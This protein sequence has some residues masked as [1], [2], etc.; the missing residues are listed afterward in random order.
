MKAVAEWEVV[1]ST[2]EQIEA[3]AKECRRMVSRRALL[4]AGVAV[5]PIPGV[6]WAT[7]VGVLLKVLPDINRKFGLSAEQVERLAPDRRL[8]VFKAITAG[9]TMLVGRIVT[10]E[11]VMSMLRMVGVRLSA[12]QAVK[13][14][15]I[16]GQGLSAVLTYGA[17]RYVCE[18]HIKQCVAICEQLRLPAPTEVVGG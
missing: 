14:V 18:Q 10:R 3:V 1:P 17:L 12:Q 11:L 15:P 7:N 6:D 5:V 13:Y 8:V 2:P 4:A 9:G 16:A